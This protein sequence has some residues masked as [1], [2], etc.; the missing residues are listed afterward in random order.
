MSPR[1]WFL[2]ALLLPM[3][4]E[5]VNVFACEPEW[6]ALVDEI[7]GD[8]AHVTVATTAFQ[9]PHRLQAK[10][11]LIAAIRDADLVVC[12]GADL[13]IG[14]LPLLLRRA[15][16]PEVFFAADHVRRLEVPKVVDRAQGD[17]H[18]QGNPHIHLDPRNVRRVANALADTLIALDAGNAARYAARRDDFQSR[19]AAAL[20]AWDER[21]A[22][23]AGLE[24]ASHHKSFSY[25]A[26]W[27]G[28]DVVATIESKPGIPPSGAQLASL[29]EQL[30]QRPPVAVVRTPYENEKPSLWLSA[31]LAIPALRL[32]YTIGG[33]PDVT[34]LFSL[35][36]VTLTI[37]EEYR[38]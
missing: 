32:P 2:F 15:G 31:R 1:F 33:D 11:S 35:F 6:S 7:A 21:A 17:I 12:S 5:A 38:Q 29:L 28:L 3:H 13:E 16:N 4:A 8:D 30:G 10:P 19:W 25:L 9:D 22:R 20:L 18:P 37:L 23:L 26:N 27:I 36:D 24:V 34:D 14:W